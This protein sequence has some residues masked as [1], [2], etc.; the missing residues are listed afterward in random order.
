[1]MNTAARLAAVTVLS[2]GTVAAGP[3]EAATADAAPVTQT[4]DHAVTAKRNYYGAIAVNTKTLAGAYAYNYSSKSKAIAA[5]LSK[6]KKTK[7]GKKNCRPELWVRNGCGALA[8]KKVKGGYRF[9]GGFASS[10]KSAIAKAKKA[11][12]KGGK[13]Y[14]YVCT[15]R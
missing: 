13:Y 10:K 1:M 2:L 7:D 3:V 11:A 8:I 5:A 14:A 6:C 9:Y 4:A 12:G 15:T